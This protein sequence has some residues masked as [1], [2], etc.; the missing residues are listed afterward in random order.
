M[1]CPKSE[2]ARYDLFVTVRWRLRRERER[3]GEYSSESDSS[4]EASEEDESL[5][6]PCPETDREPRAGLAEAEPGVRTGRGF[7]SGTSEIEPIDPATETGRIV[8]L[9]LALAKFVLLR[10]A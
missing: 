9:G 8:G 2:E 10:R 7:G 1:L 6:G 4:E 5:V 3:D